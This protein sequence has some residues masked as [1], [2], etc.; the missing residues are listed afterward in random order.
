MSESPRQRRFQALWTIVLVGLLGAVVILAAGWFLLISPVLAGAADASHT[1]T[2]TPQTAAA[3][4]KKR[5][6]ARRLI[7]NSAG[8][9]SPNTR[10]EEAREKFAL[11]FV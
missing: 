6:S 11:L 5:I 4:P 3:H 7:K 9:I 8:K 1:N 10:R 2:A